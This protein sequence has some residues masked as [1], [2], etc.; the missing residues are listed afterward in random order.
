VITCSLSELLD[1]QSETSLVS[2]KRN[3]MTL[4]SVREDLQTRTLSAI[5]GALG[6]L[7]YLAGLRQEDGSYSH[8]GLSRVHGEESAQRALGEAHKTALSAVLRTPISQLQAD[9]EESS[10]AKEVSQEKFVDELQKNEA[11]L[12]PPSPG[13]GSR[14]HLSSVLQALSS[15]VKNRR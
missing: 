1:H 6:K 4:K 11:Q 9:V 10:N 15:L 2:G 14:R 3:N 7:L 8:W 5:S 13:A 12:L